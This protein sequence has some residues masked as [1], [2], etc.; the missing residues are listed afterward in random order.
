MDLSEHLCQAF[1]IRAAQSKWS[2]KL[3]RGTR[4]LEL[5]CGHG[6]PG[7]LLKLAGCEVHFQARALAPALPVSLAVAP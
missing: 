1:D 4:V 5:G 6:L 2:S 3:P 7:I